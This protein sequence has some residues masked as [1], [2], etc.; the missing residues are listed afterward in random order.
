[1]RTLSQV[2]E[3]IK[4]YKEA[5]VFYKPGLGYIVWTM[6]T[7]DNLEV[8]FVEVETP[9]QGQGKELYKLWA[10]YI[11]VSGQS[12]YHSVI[13]YSLASNHRAK[14][15]YCKLGWSQRNLGQSIYRDDDTVVMWCAWNDFMRN[16]FSEKEQ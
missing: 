4:N 10:A 8:L 11:D 14:H 3:R 9:G 15:F 6:A 7:G 13:G 1:M 12:P 5:Q 2:Q 16:L